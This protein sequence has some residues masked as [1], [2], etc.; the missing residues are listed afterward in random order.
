[1]RIISKLKLKERK[2]QDGESEERGARDMFGWGK[3]L[4]IKWWNLKDVLCSLLNLSCLETISFHFNL[5]YLLISLVLA[6]LMITEVGVWKTSSLGTQLN[7]FWVRT[8]TKDFNTSNI[9]WFKK[10][11][12]SYQIRWTLKGERS[13]NKQ[14]L[15]FLEVAAA[16]L[17][18]HPKWKQDSISLIFI[19][20]KLLLQNCT[21]IIH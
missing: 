6:P 7:V 17:W 16:C 13:Y 3:W 10:D 14:L 11:H 5:H 8:I 21:W 12:L 19:Q 20:M 9:S 2:K 15:I 1:M 18:V 4:S